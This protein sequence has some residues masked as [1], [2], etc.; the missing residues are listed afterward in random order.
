MPQSTG[1]GERLPVASQRML[2]M[3]AQSTTENRPPK[4]LLVAFQAMF[5]NPLF[6]LFETPWVRVVVT[7]V[8]FFFCSDRSEG[9]LLA[10]S[11]SPKF[12]GQTGAAAELLESAS[13]GQPGKLYGLFHTNLT[14][15]PD[16]KIAFSNFVFSG[17]AGI[18]SFT[19]HRFI[20]VCCTD[21]SSPPGGVLADCCS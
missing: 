20:L 17:A 10:K 12:D 15:P 8:C 2:L 19:E 5:C 16:L 9:H 1:R 7:F 6:V 4:K 14:L 3:H 13:D 18:S 21:E 11:Q